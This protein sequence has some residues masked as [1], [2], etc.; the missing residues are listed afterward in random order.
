P[1]P[2]RRR[3]WDSRSAPPGSPT[4]AGATPGA[5]ATMAGSTARAPAAR[6]CRAR[7]PCPPS[8]RGLLLLALP[9]PR[10]DPGMRLER[11]RQRRLAAIT[12]LGGDHLQRPAATQRLLGQAHAPALQVLARRQPDHLAE[13]L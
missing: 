11:A 1:A 2:D 6:A 5:A 8:G 12:D 13:G 10:R 3:C 7:L 4:G 9:G